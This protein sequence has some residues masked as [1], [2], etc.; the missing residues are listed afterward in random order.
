MFVIQPTHLTLR[1][2]AKRSVSKGGN[3]HSA[4]KIIAFPTFGCSLSVALPPFETLAALAPQGEVV[5]LQD[6][7]SQALRMSGGRHSAVGLRR[8]PPLTSPCTAGSPR[9][10][11]APW[12]RW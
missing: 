9:R 4:R 6:K 8:S 10:W 11:R 3:R 5:G 12:A 2:V 7:H 1:S